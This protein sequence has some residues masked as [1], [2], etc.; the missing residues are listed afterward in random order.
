[1]LVS[2]HQPEFVGYLGYYA[3]IIQ[4]DA[5]IFLDDVQYIKR[6]YIHRNRIRRGDEVEWLTIPVRTK[7]RYTQAVK[8]VEIDQASP[9]ER[10]SWGVCRPPMHGHPILT[11]TFQASPS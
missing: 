5:H 8:E 3:K 6:G 10:N 9:G 11:N 2:I 7:G 4:G 1:M